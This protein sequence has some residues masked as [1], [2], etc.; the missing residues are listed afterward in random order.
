MQGAPQ[1]APW[2]LLLAGLLA[3]ALAA[4]LT[5]PAR[6]GVMQPNTPQGSQVTL[7][8]SGSGPMGIA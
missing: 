5:H 3:L 4:A 6:A 1:L 7:P 2:G 8:G